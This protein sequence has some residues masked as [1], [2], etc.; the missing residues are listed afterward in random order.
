MFFPRVHPRKKT[1]G[2]TAKLGGLQRVTQVRGL[3]GVFVDDTAAQHGEDHLGFE[4]L[5]GLDREEIAVK[6]VSAC[7]PLSWQV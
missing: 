4:D 2:L 5:L 7:R 1:K 6:D 3:L